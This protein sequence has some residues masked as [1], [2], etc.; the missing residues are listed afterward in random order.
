MKIIPVPIRSDNYMYLLAED[1]S[2]TGSKPKA[3]IID[4][5]D[6]DALGKFQKVDN[7]VEIVGILTTHHHEDHAG[8]NSIIAKAL[9]SIAIYGGQPANGPPQVEAVNKVVKDRDT[10]KLGDAITITCLATPCHTQDSICY[11][12]TEGDQKAVFTGDTLFQGGCGRFFEGTPEE[13]DTSLSYLGTLPDETIVYNGHEYTKGNLKF[14]KTVDPSN[15]AL[16]RLQQLCDSNEITT[17]KSTIGDEKEWNVFMR[18]DSE[19]VL[20]ATG[21]T[22][23][24]KVMGKLRE[25]KNAM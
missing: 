5:A 25:M 4:P 9:P 22:E 15:D 3:F 7:N 10:I 16:S 8:G 14:A 24:A 17:G 19:P 12:V 18:L 23:K 1:G 13:M 21:E 20:K 2:S 11:Y 6:P